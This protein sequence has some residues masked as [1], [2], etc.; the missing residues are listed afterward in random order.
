MTMKT[1]YLLL[2]AI[3]LLAACSS[4][5]DAAYNVPTFEVEITN[6]GSGVNTEADDFAPTITANGAPLVSRGSWSPRDD[7]VPPPSLERVLD[8][9][10]ARLCG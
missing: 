5:P 8:V 1:T 9:H 2:S 10:S 7:D 3:L 4:T 6:L